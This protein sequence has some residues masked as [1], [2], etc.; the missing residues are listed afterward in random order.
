[1]ANHANI[2]RRSFFRGAFSLG[3]AAAAV[4]AAHASVEEDTITVDRKTYLRQTERIELAA[5]RKRL[6]DHI[7][8][9]L[10][11]EA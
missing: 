11:R 2:T 7:I 5:D 10:G 3:A 6:P 4:T 8:K 9:S 1:M